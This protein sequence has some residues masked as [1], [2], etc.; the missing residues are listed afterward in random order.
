MPLSSPRGV[1]ATTAPPVPAPL[2]HASTVVLVR[3]A[4]GGG[5]EAYLVRRARTMAFAGG[6]YAYPGGRVDPADGGAALPWAGPPLAGL[7]APLE[8]EPGLAQALA[9]AAVRE[10]FEECGVLLAGPADDPTAALDVTGPRW[11]ADRRAMEDR[12]LGLGDLL[13]RHGLALRGDLLAP[14]AR[15]ITP[16]VE[17]RR[18]DTRFFMA[19]L[20][21][22]Q[23]PG[24]V[25]A[26]ADQGG[27]IRPE[28]A[29]ERHAAG[30]M[31]M[32]PPT[33]WM[34][35]DLLEFGDTASVL[36]A[37][38]ERVIIPVLPKIVL[39]D[40]AVHFLLPHN[41]EY[42]LAA[43]PA[44]PESARAIIEA[45]AAGSAHGA[46]TGAENAVPSASRTGERS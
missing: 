28:V 35:A 22:G 1:L 44:D 11:D 19:A 36:A 23:T 45:T 12:E 15:W 27:W 6:V 38:T 18:Y 8:R 46:W 7:L 21:T 37:A 3:D 5:V 29:L 16:E 26:E 30:Q 17:P 14:W 20:P 32:L 2:R 24:A 4:P 42:D 31:L 41:A 34:L 9:Y 13:S 40:E 39:S 25:S 43:P 33:A 10:T